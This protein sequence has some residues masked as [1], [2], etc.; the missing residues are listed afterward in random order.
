MTSKKITAWL[1]SAF[2]GVCGLALSEFRGSLKKSRSHTHKYATLDFFSATH[3]IHLKFEI[4]QIQ[5][6]ILACLGSYSK[7]VYARHCAQIRR[8]C[9]TIHKFK[10]TLSFPSLRDFAKQNRGNPLAFCKANALRWAY[11]EAK[12]A[13]HYQYSALECL[14]ET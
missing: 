1:L 12:S 11:P 7:R 13:F 8:I 4:W 6:W 5:F 14:N 3:E 2:R 9:A 10:Q